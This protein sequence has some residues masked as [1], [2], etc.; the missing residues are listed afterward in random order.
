MHQYRT[1][2]FR[3]DGHFSCVQRIE[4]ADER[5]AAQKARQLVSR[6]DGELW[7]SDH[8]IA[9]FPDPKRTTEAASVGGLVAEFGTRRRPSADPNAAQKKPPR[10]VPHR[11]G[12]H[13][14]RSDARRECV[15]SQGLML[16][17]G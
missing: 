16:R 7:E 12:S 8:L 17:L 10:R 3:D 6:Q 11:G 1:Y 4:C 15:R 5:K 14:V 2:T 13:L 9:R